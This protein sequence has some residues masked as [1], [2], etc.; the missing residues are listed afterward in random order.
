MPPG[1]AQARRGCSAT[2]PFVAN[3]EHIFRVNSPLEGGR[4]LCL[5]AGLHVLPD[6]ER[7][8]WSCGLPN[9]FVS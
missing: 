7:L 2:S 4:P 3:R 8:R 1:P 6:R 9:G 5:M